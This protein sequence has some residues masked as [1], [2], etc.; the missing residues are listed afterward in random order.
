MMMSTTKE[1]N[2]PDTLPAMN[3]KYMS[4]ALNEINRNSII[5]FNFGTLLWI[6]EL[7]VLRSQLE[8]KQ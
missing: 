1:I 4:G 6:I 7:F 2:R 5:Q 8:L 3:I